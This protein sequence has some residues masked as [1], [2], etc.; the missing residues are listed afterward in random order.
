MENLRFSQRLVGPGGGGLHGILRVEA[1]QLAGTE[2]VL[3]IVVVVIV[4]A[5]KA[6]AVVAA[7]MVGPARVLRLWRG[8]LH[9]TSKPEGLRQI[10]AV[11]E[12][13]DVLGRNGGRMGQFKAKLAPKKA[14]SM[15]LVVVLQE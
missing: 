12:D 3:R 11:A 10:G 14:L 7:M 1:V 5:I 13:R 8:A 15:D 6:A 4:V 9:E 2:A